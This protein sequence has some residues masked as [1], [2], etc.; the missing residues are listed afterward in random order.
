M[1]PPSPTRLDIPRYPLVVATFIKIRKFSLTLFEHFLHLL[2]LLQVN[3]TVRQLISL[4]VALK[5]QVQ[6]PHLAQT[7]SPPGKGQG[8]LGVLLDGQIEGL[9]GLLVAALPEIGTAKVMVVDGYIRLEFHGASV[10]LDGLLVLLERIVSRP[11]VSVIGALIRIQADGLLDK[12]YLEA[13]I[14]QLPHRFPLQMVELAFLAYLKTP[15]T[16]LGQFLP[17]LHLQQGLSHHQINFDAACHL[18]RE[19]DHLLV[20]FQLQQL[21]QP[22]KRRSIALTDQ[23][24]AVSYLF[25]FDLHALYKLWLIFNSLKQCSAASHPLSAFWPDKP[26]I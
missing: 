14:S 25:E 7:V 3:C 11:N 12:F 20:L 2:L 23:S 26:S 6:F 21:P 8:L 18:L 22:L 1:N 4:L 19:S 15:I 5:R 10:V 13:R 17:L 24:F 9:Q 16:A